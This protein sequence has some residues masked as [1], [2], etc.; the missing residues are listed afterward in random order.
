MLY[1]PAVYIKYILY[2]PAVYY[3]KEAD[4][5]YDQPNSSIT[6]INEYFCRQIRLFQSLRKAV[7]IN[8]DELCVT[9]RLTE[10]LESKISLNCPKL[11][12]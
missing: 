2:I 10:G 12:L 3:L 5:Q 11:P 7:E 4:P 6:L 8:I 9:V 1:V